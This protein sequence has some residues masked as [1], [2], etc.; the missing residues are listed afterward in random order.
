MVLLALNTHED[1]IDEK[2]ILIPLMTTL[3]SPGISWSKLVTPQPNG[4][5]AHGNTTFG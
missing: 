3:Q 5:T 4:F 1:F 2:R